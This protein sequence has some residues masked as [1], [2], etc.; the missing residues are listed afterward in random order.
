MRKSGRTTADTTSRRSARTGGRKTAER[1]EPAGC[2]RADHSGAATGSTE[3]QPDERLTTPR[4]LFFAL[5]FALVGGLVET[6]L[7]DLGIRVGVLP[8]LSPHYPWMIPAA[9][10][11]AFAVAAPALLVVGRFRPRLRAP[12]VVIG[13]FAGLAALGVLLFF[14]GFHDAAMAV[15]A[16]GIGVQTGRLAEGRLGRWL[17]RIVPPATVA[18]TLVVVLIGGRVVV[19]GVRAEAAALAALPAAE[20]GSANVLFLILDT[21]RAASLGLYDPAKST[22]PELEAFAEAATVFDRAYSPSPW[23]LPSHASMFTGRRPHEHGASWT[24]PLDGRFPTLAEALSAAGYRTTAFVANLTFATRITGL[25]RGFGRYE[26]Y[27]ISIGQVVLSSALGRSLAL[28]DPLRAMVGVHDLLNR[29]DAA[30]IT[31]RFLEWQAEL[32]S[33]RPFFAFL[34]YFDAHEPFF[35][36]SGD[37]ADIASTFEHTG[38]LGVG[39]SAAFERKWEMD[40]MQRRAYRNAYERAIG[41]VD[42]QLGRLF[43]ELERRG[44][45]D[46]TLVVV[47]GDHGEQLGEHN[48]FGHHNS[49]YLPALH[50]PLV[51]RYPGVADGGRR[52]S[53][54]VDIRSLPATVAD[55]L[56]LDTRFPGRSLARVGGPDADDESADTIVAQLRTGSDVQS[57]YPT[58]RGPVMFS[59]IQSGHHYIVNGDGTR[60]LYDLAA[61]PGQTENLA[62]D[63]GSAATVAELHGVLRSSVEGSGR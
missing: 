53:T 47:V 2:E 35:P 29:K 62:D 59:L 16:A 4:I 44:V 22:T 26:D 25:A 33:G 12:S 32:G 63:P 57:W 20:A 10:V 9:H 52:V 48:L 19:R 27:P 51:I 14:E 18:L 56:D 8:R 34:N 5:F 11:L 40:E 30:D 23:T 13:G 6:A 49:L 42:A 24:R 50:V 1:G 21:V 17:D 41:R 43:R 37:P 39:T 61:D 31:D 7:V 3:G 60:E 58:A 54:A 45:L 46:E 28:A 15:L 55:V 38:G 36:P